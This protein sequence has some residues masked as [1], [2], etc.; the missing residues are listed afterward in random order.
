MNKI[1]FARQCGTL[2]GM[3]FKAAPDSGTPDMEFEITAIGLRDA[4]DFDAVELTFSDGEKVVA[5]IECLH[6]A[7]E[8][9][10]RVM[11]RL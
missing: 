7:I 1:E 8:R 11:N 2:K 3:K 6:E 10:C 4:D 9:G 5:A